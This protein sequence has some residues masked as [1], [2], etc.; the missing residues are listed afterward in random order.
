MPVTLVRYWGSYFKSARHAGRIAAYFARTASA[1]WRTYLV[2]C[3]P[4]DDPSWTDDVR[5]LGVEIVYLPRAS[6]NFDARCVAR[7]FSLCRRVQADVFH[8]DNTHTS[9]LIG[10]A[11]AGV[12][13]RVWSKR[14]MEPAFEEGREPT[15][16]ERAAVSL[17][18]SC[19]L[20]NR[21]L[22]VSEMVGE[23]LVRKGIRASKIRV[24]HSA[25]EPGGNEP[26][27]RA[28]ARARLGC[29]E[30]DFVIATVGRADP[31]KGWDLLIRAFGE[32][33][34][35]IPNATLLLAGGIES[36][37]ES[38]FRAELDRIARAHSV[39]SA[40]RYTGRL[41]NVSDVLGA[42]D[43]FVLPSRSE[44]HSLALVEALRA[45]L[46]CV[47]TAVGGGP[48]L[49]RDGRNG[50][51]VPREDAGALA[52]AI[53]KLGGDPEGRAR[54]AAAAREGLRM[55]TPDEHA[56]ALYDVYTSLRARQP[57]LL[58]PGV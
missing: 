45:G 24:L 15:L 53:L 5:R 34:Q 51:L 36:A 47:S 9:P 7:T 16:R 38:G 11:M 32:V 33:R 3:Q 31:V 13:V 35:A 10:A 30:G 12:R 55:P 44:G 2:C 39:S 57:E 18:L 37:S 14:S 54:M 23:E 52:R 46:P 58:A 48:E 42:A 20:A 40:V 19:L 26:S 56:Q 49:I 4:P 50:W 21:I 1:G 27:P 17:R 29:A 8:C 41:P 25:V 43:A 6:G 28:V 22:P